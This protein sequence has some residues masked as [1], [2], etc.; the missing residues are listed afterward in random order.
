MFGN[1]K[2]NL[3]SKRIS[4][5]VFLFLSV[6]GNSRLKEWRVFRPSH[7]LYILC[8]IRVLIC[9]ENNLLSMLG[10]TQRALNKIWK[11]FI[12]LQMKGC[13]NNWAI[14][15]YTI[16][17]NAKLYLIWNKISNNSFALLHIVQ[18]SNSLK[19]VVLLS[20]FLTIKLRLWKVKCFLLITNF[21]ENIK[22][23]IVRQKLNYK[24]V[25]YPPKKAIRAN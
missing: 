18:F 21:E 16:D 20:T 3:Q 12:C 25:D 4:K 22:Y 8:Y 6:T 7:N 13:E 15:V 2:T 24:R 17:L 1:N 11:H 5:Y 10:C 14:Y 23:F 9:Q 19:M